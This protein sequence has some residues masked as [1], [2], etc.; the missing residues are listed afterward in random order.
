MLRS[1]EVVV[2]VS[3]STEEFARV[4]GPDANVF[5]I[6][7]VDVVIIDDGDAASVGV[8]LGLVHRD[9]GQRF[10]QLY[11]C[12]PSLAIDVATEVGVAATAIV[13]GQYR[14]DQPADPDVSP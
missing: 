12:P 6:V 1:Q 11:E 2:V 5:T 7:S 9:T 4:Y 13:T 10:R 8:V 14:D 3:L